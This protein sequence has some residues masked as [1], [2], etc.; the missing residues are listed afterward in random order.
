MAKRR[1]K[2]T[3][4]KSTII[5]A[6]AEMAKTKNIDRDLLQGIVEETLVMIIRKKYGPDANFEIIVNME[7]G[8]VEI[9]LMRTIV[10]EVEDENLEISLDEVQERTDEEYEI[11]EEFV[12]EITLENIS[13]SFGRRLVSLAYQNLNQ[14][15]RE[16]E[17]DNVYNEYVQKT[18]EIIIGEIYQVRR[19]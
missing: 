6:F 8:D 12:E 14:R 18:G 17:K 1:K 16:V 19:N 3:A 4:D 13:D 11:G 2:H 9:Y 10:E 15:I 5:D 7:K